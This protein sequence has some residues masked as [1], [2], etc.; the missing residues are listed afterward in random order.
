MKFLSLLGVDSK[1]WIV[2]WVRK[3][4]III[5]HKPDTICIFPADFD[6]KNTPAYKKTN[7]YS[8]NMSSTV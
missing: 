4:I 8:G 3:E 5:I 7:L 2:T 1:M 6:N